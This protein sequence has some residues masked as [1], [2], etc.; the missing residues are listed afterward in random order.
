M[1][2]FLPPEWAPQAATLLIWPRAGGD[3]SE[4]LAPARDAM[5]A[6]AATLATRQKV[7]LIAADSE[8]RGSI[9][10]H[11]DL[12]DPAP[13]I[14]ELP[15]NDVWVRDT[16]PITVFADHGRRRFLDFHFDGWGGRYPSVDDDAL[17]ARLHAC[18]ALGAGE[19]IRHD[20]V[21][22]GGAVESD[23]TG[24]LLTTERCLLHGRRNPGLDRK[25]LEKRLAE[26][27]GTRR[28]LWLS[29]GYLEGDDTD[30][31]ID[32]LARFAAPDH[33]VHQGCDNPADEHHRPLAAM[34][35][36]LSTLRTSGGRP[37]RLTALPLPT[38]QYDDDGRRLPA[39]YANF[40][41]ANGMLLAPAYDDPAD[42]KAHAAL[43][44]C[45]PDRGL[46]A[47]DCRALIRQNGALHC[48]AM[49]IP[50]PQQTTKC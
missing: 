37:Y 33:I 14:V 5:A 41:L 26:T 30:G 48:A 22:E 24:T 1:P 28:I 39:G 31:H 16:G 4:Q 25:A 11:P 7:I 29:E 17:A 2:P 40:L 8:C 42:A 19:L 34:A 50:L 36:E 44:N 21:L 3:W 49:Q 18:G 10:A 27:L 9:A 6:M 38:P 23:G 12:A 43:A 20:W 47:I 13:Q 35:Q 32:T 45:F 15:N 46:I